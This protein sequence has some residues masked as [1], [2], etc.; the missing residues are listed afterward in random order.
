[1]EVNGNSKVQCLMN[2]MNESELPGQVLT[3]FVWSSRKQRKQM[4]L[5]YPDGRWCAFCWLILDAFHWGL[6]S[7][8]LIDNSTCWDESF[9]LAHHRGCPSIYTTLPSL[10]EDWPLVWLVVGGHFT[11]PVIFSIPHYCT[12]PSFHRPTEFVLKNGFSLCFSRKLQV[13]IRSRR[14]FFTYVEPKH[15]S[16]ELDQAA[17]NDFQH[18]IWVFW[19][20]WLSPV[21]CTIDYSQL[22]SWS[23]C[24]QLQLVYP[25]VEHH[26]V[27]NLQHK[28]S[29]TTFDTF[30][31]SIFSIHGTIFFFF[32]FF[33]FQLRFYLSWNNEA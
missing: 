23:D 24:Y 9:G 6:L 16:D 21:W 1:M 5:H 27:R 30:S 15:Q 8:G 29:K 10:D 19:V 20:C 33:A 13:E 4:I 32:F 12:V 26:P 2:V 17:A 22:M 7:V 31:H 25:I 3:V 18:L 14:F 11:F 28:T